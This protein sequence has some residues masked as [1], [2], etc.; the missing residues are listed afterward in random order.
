VN[1]WQLFVEKLKTPKGK[2]ITIIVTIVVIILSVLSWI[3][4]DR[5]FKKSIDQQSSN[6][7]INIKES[8]ELEKSVSKLDGIKYPK[9]KANRN[10]IAIMVENHPEARPQVGMENASIIYEAEAEGG[11]TR[12]MAV[13]GPNDANMIGPVRSARTYFVDW[14]LELKSFYAHCGGSADGLA[15]IQQ[16][17]LKNLDQFKVGN[18][19][20]WREVENKAS[21][22]TLYTNTSKL[23]DVAKSYDWNVSTSDFEPYRFKKDNK[24]S[25]RPE[26]QIITV[27]FSG[28]LYS[29]TWTYSQENNDYYR[30]MAGSPHKDRVSGNQLT[31]KNIIVQEIPRN[32]ITNSAGV[33]LWQLDTV[34][35]G[36]ALIFID[37]QKIEAKW[38]KSQRGSRTKF[39]DPEN[40]EVEF[41]P[42]Q[43]WIQVVAPG[44]VITEKTAESV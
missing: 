30:S 1:K 43:T 2:K 21:E 29:T 13:Y 17:G 10:P 34:G 31:A 33:T 26:S 22:H 27:P 35:E 3:I 39:Y 9:D 8:D 36:K 37:G 44:A 5:Y 15:L 18:S 41:N 38:K 42:G 23:R 14:A 25:Q 19:A 28:G 24:E 7:L 11:I 20:Y 40:N 12:F 16:T 4:Y 6:L 32:L